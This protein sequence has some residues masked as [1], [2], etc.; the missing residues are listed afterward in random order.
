MPCKKAKGWGKYFS[1]NP[2]LKL[3]YFWRF[4]GREYSKFSAAMTRQ[5]WSYLRYRHGRS[6]IVRIK[7]ISRGEWKC[8]GDYIFVFWWSSD[9]LLRNNA[10]SNSGTFC[11][12]PLGISEAKW[13]YLTIC[14]Q[15]RY[16]HVPRRIRQGTYM[17][18]VVYDRV[19]T[20]TWSYTSGYTY[21]LC[22]IRQGTHM[23][24]DGYVRVHISKNTVSFSKNLYVGSKW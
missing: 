5:R 14:T 12:H 24:P 9:N 8:P 16:T 17:Y 2:Q 3:A 18:P 4:R 15:S 20:C 13:V 1:Q 19:H 23:Y 6:F 10:T 7:R 22:R 21:V 11:P